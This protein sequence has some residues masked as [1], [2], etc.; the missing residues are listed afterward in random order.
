MRLRITCEL[1]RQIAC[2][3]NHQ[4]FLTGLVYRLLECSDANYARFLHDEGYGLE[5]DARRFKLFTFS[6]LRA[7]RRR[8]MGDTLW[9]GPGAVSWFIASPVEDFLTHIATGLLSSGVLSVGP[10]LELPITQI[11]TQAAPDF[12]AGAAHFTCL[13]PIVA[14]VPVEI[15]GKSGTRY[16]RPAEDA[17]A[18]SEAVRK[19]LIRKYQTLHEG[20]SPANA[21][22]FELTFSADY[23]AAHRGGTKNIEFKGIQII[24]AQAPFSV[25]SGGVE[26]LQTMWECGAG[27]KNSSGFGMVELDGRAPQ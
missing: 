8:I 15:N 2:P 14:A 4:H 21:N 26:L 22:D 11:E 24:G 10:T 7:Q 13:S 6:G 27:E 1:A 19:N 20:K 12:S 25:V 17:P 23:L 16:L 18:F 3:V 5:A 9:L